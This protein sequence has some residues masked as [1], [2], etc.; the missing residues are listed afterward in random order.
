MDFSKSLLQKD[1]S[2]FGTSMLMQFSYIAHKLHLDN[3][4]HGNSKHLYNLPLCPCPWFSDHL[5]CI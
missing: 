2:Y 1:T 3:T 5:L 4:L